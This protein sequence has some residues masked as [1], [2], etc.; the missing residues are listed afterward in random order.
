MR[1]HLTSLLI[2]ASTA[3]ISPIVV[4]KA[5][6]APQGGS[7]FDASTVMRN[8]P[9]GALRTDST[10]FFRLEQMPFE[11]EAATTK[12]GSASPQKSGAPVSH[13]TTFH[14]HFK[15]LGAIVQDVRAARSAGETS[16]TIDGYHQMLGALTAVVDPA[17]SRPSRFYR[18]MMGGEEMLIESVLGMASFASVDASRTVFMH[19]E[20]VRTMLKHRSTKVSDPDEVAAVD[21]DLARVKLM[22]AHTLMQFADGMASLSEVYD[23]QQSAYMES[24]VARQAMSGDDVETQE[25][26]AAHIGGSGIDVRHEFYENAEQKIKTALHLVDAT[27][28]PEMQ[29]IRFVGDLLLIEALAKQTD[30]SFARRDP[31]DDTKKL[32]DKLQASLER[33]CATN[34]REPKTRQEIVA[35][36]VGDAAT[37]CMRLGD[38]RRGIEWARMVVDSASAYADAVAS[39]ELLKRPEFAR[40]V[41]ADATKIMSNEELGALVPPGTR[42]KNFAKA[43]LANAHSSGFMET[44][45]VGAGGAALGCL[46]AFMMTG[47]DPSPLTTMFSMAG[48]AAVARGAMSIWNGSQSP[49]AQS[50]KVHGI[51]ER[52]PYEVGKDALRILGRGVLDTGLWTIPSALVT[53]FPDVYDLSRR[54]LAPAGDMYGRFAMWFAN[55]FNPQTYAGYE[56]NLTAM[57][58]D[59]AWGALVSIRRAYEA[60]ALGMYLSH[61]MVRSSRPFIE[62][63]AKWFVPAAVCLGADLGTLIAGKDDFYDRLKR[64]SMALVEGTAMLLAGGIIALSRT[65]SVNETLGSIYRGVAK[66]NHMNLVAIAL[67][68]GVSSAVGGQMQRGK[69]VSNPLLNIVQGGMI[70]VGLLGITLFISGVLKR[71]I[72]LGQGIAEGWRDSEGDHPLR[73]VYESIMGGVAAFASPYV[74]NRTFR[75]VTLDLIPAGVRTMMPGGWDSNLGYGSMAGLNFAGFNPWAT[76]T[77][78]ETGATAWERDALKRILIPTNKVRD[79]SRELFDHLQKAGQRLSP[80]HIFYPHAPADRLWPLL[81]IRRIWDPPRFPMTPNPRYFSSFTQFL[82]NRQDISLTGEELDQLLLHITCLASNPRN[83]EVL[84][85]VVKALYLS[86]SSDA[87]GDDVDETEGA[88]ATKLRRFFAENPWLIDQLNI[89]RHAL[90]RPTTKYRRKLRASIGRMLAMSHETYVKRVR[91]GAATYQQRKVEKAARKQARRLMIADLGGGRERTAR[92]AEVENDMILHPTETEV[93]SVLTMTPKERKAH[94]EKRHLRAIAQVDA[95]RYERQISHEAHLLRDVRAQFA[96]NDKDR[97]INGLFQ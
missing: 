64:G 96:M 89:D 28:H 38:T 42:R 79:V 68:V 58:P 71:D 4:H 35:T 74:Q 92:I 88:H 65:G 24:L 14:D 51:Y 93:A 55:R 44:L 31:A 61:C 53:Y 43:S 32:L 2:P 13:A 78:P 48:G 30:C 22:R 49:V 85:P 19:L 77:W 29:D 1:S 41:N 7:P 36:Y 83:Y 45:A 72:P 18:H 86:C 84:R 33:V 60:M 11:F 5:P 15:E 97:P 39:H 59:S 23:Q 81:A 47:G 21:A 82:M 34:V 63:Y 27:S 9:R 8:I 76:S 37:M 67:T 12:S 54:T 46:G 20:Q 10:P 26:D 52:E 6:L 50:V 90:V 95:E 80:L 62:K 87:Q 69:P 91:A 16:A 75:S 17:S 25:M 57:Q 66:A 94:A 40:Y 70:T 73:R 3:S 56:F